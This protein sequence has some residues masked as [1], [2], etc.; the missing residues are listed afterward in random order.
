MGF[1]NVAL[2]GS[3]YYWRKKITIAGV[4]VPMAL[5]LDTGRF[6]EACV[7]ALRLGSALEAL[8]MAYGQSSGMAPDKLRQIFGDAMRWQLQRILEEQAGNHARS[9]DHAALNSIHAEAWDFLAR[10]G[11]EAKWSLDDHDR[12]IGS[13][14]HPDDAKAVGNAVFD[15]QATHPVSGVQ[16]DTYAKSFGID[17]SGENLDRMKRTVCAAR[18]AAC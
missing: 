11:V 13:G 4:C 5:P 8:R 9:V 3:T 15:S 10:H 14:W 12:L 6:K 2:R 16:L 7:I 18:A 17:K 1:P